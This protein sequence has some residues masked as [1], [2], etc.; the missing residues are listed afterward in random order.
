MSYTVGE[1]KVAAYNWTELPNMTVE[2]RY[3]WQG[4]G[5][6]YEA[7]RAEPEEKPFLD[8]LSKDYIETFERNTKND[9]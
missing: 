4:L 5:Y 3:L 9:S 6:C 2:E 8:K 1:I 7:Y